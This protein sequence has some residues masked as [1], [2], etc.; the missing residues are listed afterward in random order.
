ML[1]DFNM[2]NLVVHYVTTGPQRVNF[3]QASICN[4]EITVY[5]IKYM[6][7]NQLPGKGEHRVK[8]ISWFSAQLNKLRVSISGYS[9]RSLTATLSAR[10]YEAKSKN[11]GNVTPCTLV[12]SL[13]FWKSLLFPP[14]GVGEKRDTSFILDKGCHNTAYEICLQNNICFL[15]K[16]HDYDPE[17]RLIKFC[18]KKAPN[19]LWLSCDT[20][21]EWTE[22][23]RHRIR[24]NK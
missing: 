15:K 20:L 11:Y 24:G 2:W 6:F 9:P 5:Y 10:Q 1:V 14:L 12:Q 4:S 23:K 19:H 21:V 3:H 8:S 18:R 7:Q 13:Y 17:R 22:I 16:A